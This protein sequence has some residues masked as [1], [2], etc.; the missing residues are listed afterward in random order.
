MHNH[1]QKK[2]LPRCCPALLVAAT[3]CFADFHLGSSLPSRRKPQHRLLSLLAKEG[4]VVPHCWSSCRREVLL[5]PC[6]CLISI[7]HLHREAIAL[8][9]SCHRREVCKLL[10][11]KSGRGDQHW[12]LKGRA[13]IFKWQNSSNSCTCTAKQKLGIM[14]GRTLI[15]I[16][17]LSTQLDALVWNH[18]TN[19]QLSTLQPQN[20]IIWAT[21]GKVLGSQI[22]IIRE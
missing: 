10:L 15:F 6:C 9:E 16:Y 13:T 22:I 8:M 19:L 21:A 17:F 11:V 1:V 12:R 3:W 20:F 5:D 14:S 4:V 2:L 7:L 18:H